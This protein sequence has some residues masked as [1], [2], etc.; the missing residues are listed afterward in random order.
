MSFYGVAAFKFSL[1]ENK[2]SATTCILS[3][4]VCN[5]SPRVVLILTLP[6][7]KLLASTKISLFIGLLS[8]LELVLTKS[9]ITDIFFECFI[10]AEISESLVSFKKFL[11]S[12]THLQKQ[13]LRGVP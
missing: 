5:L 6:D 2:K 7:N 10:T 4:R 13:Q 3:P 11:S 9:C 8:R 12:D 1:K